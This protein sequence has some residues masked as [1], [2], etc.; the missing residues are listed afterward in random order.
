MNSSRSVIFPGSHRIHGRVTTKVTTLADGSHVV[1]RTHQ[2]GVDVGLLRALSTH[3]DRRARQATN[4]AAVADGSAHL[5]NVR[6]FL[7]QPAADG[8]AWDA[9]A[10][11]K[12]P[13]LTPEQWNAKQD[14]PG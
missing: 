5:D 7:T 13:K 10:W 12:P 3:V 4:Q 1:E 11:N 8:A 14:G 9:M 2:Q 6:V